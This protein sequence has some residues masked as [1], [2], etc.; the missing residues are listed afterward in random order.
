MK[1]IDEILS[2]LPNGDRYV[3]ED[4]IEELTDDI[5]K[6]YSYYDLEDAKDESYGEG[7][8]HG[9]RLSENRLWHLHN[10]RGHAG[11]IDMCHL[12]PCIR[13]SS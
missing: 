5:G 6:M 1:T 10:E 4:Y 13:A 12:E 9:Q 11:R 7:F 8:M 3:I 2:Q